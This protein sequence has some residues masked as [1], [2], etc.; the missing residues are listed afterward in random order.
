MRDEKF[1]GLGFYSPTFLKMY[2]KTTE[3]LLDC[4]DISI[5]TEATLFHEYIHFLQDITSTFGFMNIS[6]VVDYMKYCNTK[7]LDNKDV[8]FKVPIVPEISQKFYSKENWELR[9]IYIGDG[10]GYNDISSIISVAPKKV[11][12][13]LNGDIVSI[14]Q[15]QI[16]YIDS[17]GH[18]L[19]YLIGEYCI[20]ESMA[21]TM[22]QILYPGVLETPNKL[23]YESI[24]MICDF[25]M[26]GFT[27]NLENLIAICDVCLMSFNPGMFFFNVLSDIQKNGGIESPEDI[28]RK[29][30]SGMRFNYKGHT[31]L[32][33]LFIS[34]GSQAATQLSDYFT[35]EIF[36]ENRSWMNYIISS[37]MD[38][39]I[40]HPFFM[41]QIVRNG[42]YLENGKI[43]NR[44]LNDL[45][46]KLGSPLAINENFEASL[47]MTTNHDYNISIEYLWVINQVY[48][49]YTNGLKNDTYK[50]EMIE[51]CKSSCEE[52]KIEDYTDDR[53]RYDPWLRS[54]DSDP[55]SCTFGRL[56]KTWGLST[57]TPTS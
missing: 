38:L 24:K 31:S 33:Q 12:V 15:L 22:E 23:P 5:E 47:V 40:T 52:N 1:N 49:I 43:N 10:K 11:E 34:Q 16:I 56:W 42:K 55:N 3:S 26:P 21:Y 20:S 39:R 27:N 30:H 19:K 44:F 2:V 29:A 14:E 36:D 51:W 32:Q 46:S 28:Y 57:K 53:C 37:G 25:M 13:E 9:K 18:E 45:I 41:L 48:K 35:T 4:R 54:K 50:C 6:N 7:I 8:K 17:N